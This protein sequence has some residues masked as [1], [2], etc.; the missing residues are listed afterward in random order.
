MK[1]LSKTTSFLV[2]TGGLSLFLVGIFKILGGSYTTTQGAFL[3]IGYMLV[4]AISVFLVEKLIYKEEELKQRLLISFKV[5]R[6]FFISWLLTPLIGFGALGISLLF[7]SVSYSPGMEGMF[8][9]FAHL[10]TT[11]QVEE[12]QKSLDDIP[13][14]PILLSLLQG[15]VAGTTINALATFGEEL[16]WRGFLVRQFQNMKFFKA[17]LVMGFIWGIW[18]APII[19]MGHNYPNYPVIGVGMMTIFCM[20]LSP[21]FLYVTLKAKSVIA[22][23]IMHGT[24][25]ATGGISILVI[26]GGHDLM[27]GTTGLAGFITL[28]ILTLG[29]AFYDVVISKEKLITK[30]I[31]GSLKC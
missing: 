25:N 12:M 22:A 21:L 23:S 27:V 15:L 31:R 14:N 24:L 8:E 13:L 30:Q 26:S 7:P 11:E 18:H 5:N 16:G 6:W 19:L 17:S 4:P 10:L 2:I 1:K 3:A 29:I 20:L 28:I 9:R